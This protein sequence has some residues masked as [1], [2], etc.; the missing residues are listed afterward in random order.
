MA[1]RP[2]HPN[3]EIEAALRYAEGHGWVIEKASGHAHKWGTMKCPTNSKECWG[4]ANCLKG[5]WGTP[6]C[7]EDHAKQI[8]SI[9]DKCI[10]PQKDEE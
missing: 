6:R 4:G 3:K 2:R 9:V 1:E 10:Y 5:I 7:P 8:R